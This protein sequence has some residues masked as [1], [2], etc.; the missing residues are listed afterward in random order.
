MKCFYFHA[1]DIELLILV[2]LLC[3]FLFAG[4]GYIEL[5]LFQCYY[6][7]ARPWYDDLIFVGIFTLHVNLR[8]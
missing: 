6:N 4:H 2:L 7:V 3:G 5:N 8:S 1:F